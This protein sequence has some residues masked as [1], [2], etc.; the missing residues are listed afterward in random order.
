MK[1]NHPHRVS[2]PVSASWLLLGTPTVAKADGACRR[3][4]VRR[5]AMAA[6]NDLV[7]KPQAPEDSEAGCR[8]AAG[9]DANGMAGAGGVA[10]A[11]AAAQPLFHPAPGVVRVLWRRFRPQKPGNFPAS[12]PLQISFP[13]T[14]AGMETQRTKPKQTKTNNI[15]KT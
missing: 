12:G 9:V 4:P 1:M 15:R 13:V 5:N 3:Y 6:E 14:P 8:G 11:T 2:G 7:P 10:A